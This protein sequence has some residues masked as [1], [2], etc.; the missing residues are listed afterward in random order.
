L[1]IGRHHDRDECD[2]K[3]FH[4]IEPEWEIGAIHCSSN[5]AATARKRND[6][7]IHHRTW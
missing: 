2:K 5:R 7:L 1:R 4:K 3:A 6:R